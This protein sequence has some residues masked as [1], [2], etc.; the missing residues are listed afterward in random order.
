[1]EDYKLK[2]KSARLTD[3]YTYTDDYPAGALLVPVWV[4]ETELCYYDP[5]REITFT[6]DETYMLSA[7]DGAAL[8]GEVIWY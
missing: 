3:A 6:E 1:M 8:E 7:T 5:V 2:L 4:F